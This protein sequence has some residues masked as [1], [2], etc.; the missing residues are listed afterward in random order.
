MP[1]ISTKISPNQASHDIRTVV[2]SNWDNNG[3][4]L[5][6]ALSKHFSIV[7]DLTALKSN[8]EA[9]YIFCLL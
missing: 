7:F 9:I 2:K 8:L 3:E 1:I 6:T 5:N 4:K